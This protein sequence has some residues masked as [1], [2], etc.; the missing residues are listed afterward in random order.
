MSRTVLFSI[1]SLLFFYTTP[2]YAVNSTKSKKVN[3]LIHL[4]NSNKRSY[5]A[6]LHIR[7]NFFIRN[8]SNDA[9]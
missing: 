1:I 7:H 9:D 5:Q 2:A 8:H 4:S 3:V 6:L